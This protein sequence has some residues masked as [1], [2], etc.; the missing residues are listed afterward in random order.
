MHT[1]VLLISS[2][3]VPC[4]VLA[5]CAAAFAE[6]LLLWMMLAT[7]H[8]DGANIH[9]IFDVVPKRARIQNQVEHCPVIP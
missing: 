2:H 3:V 8:A 6:M 7:S 5:W 1:A 4:S 9:A